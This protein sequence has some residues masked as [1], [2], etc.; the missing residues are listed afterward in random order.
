MRRKQPNTQWTHAWL[1][2]KLSWPRGPSK[3]LPS[4]RRR[5][6]CFS[7]L[8]ADLAFQE[9]CS[10]LKVTCGSAWTSPK[11]C[12]MWL[13][14]GKWKVMLSIQIWVMGSDSDR[15]FSM[16]PSLF[17]LSN[18]SVLQNN[19]AKTRTNA[20]RNSSK[21][22]TPVWLRVQGALSNSIPAHHSKSKW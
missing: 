13:L 3:F 11:Q 18:G 2:F 9:M 1:I 20:F 16:E 19:P 17:R 10:V 22:C 8:V 4:Q 15:V 21:S 6:S 7:T 5:K 14:F 12:L